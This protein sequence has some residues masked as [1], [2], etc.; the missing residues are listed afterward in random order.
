MLSIKDTVF[1]EIGVNYHIK[2]FLFAATPTLVCAFSGTWL[3]DNFLY[4]AYRLSTL[5]KRK[6]RA[7]L[8][9]SCKR[10]QQNQ[11]K[12][13]NYSVL[14]DIF[15]HW[16]CQNVPLSITDMLVIDHKENVS[17]INHKIVCD[18]TWTFFLCDISQT[19]LSLQCCMTKCSV[20]N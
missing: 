19:F 3:A 12:Q 10:N 2:Y 6:L 11:Q 4:S 18:Q 14:K 9:V 13:Q 8:S 5:I 16:R 1:N 15:S 20:I 17:L 7:I